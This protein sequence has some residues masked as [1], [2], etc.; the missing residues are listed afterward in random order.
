M[1][2]EIQPRT[3]LWFLGVLDPFSCTIFGLRRAGE[4]EENEEGKKCQFGSTYSA[5]SVCLACHYT[6]RLI[7]PGFFSNPLP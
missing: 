4:E 2:T 1:L 7:I 3:Q 6:K 5:M